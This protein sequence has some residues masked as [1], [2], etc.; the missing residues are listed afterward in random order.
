MSRMLAR[1][2]A[3]RNRRG[4]LGACCFSVVAGVGTFASCIV[5][6]IVIALAA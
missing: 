1:A 2:R 4:R 5:V 6:V 3:P